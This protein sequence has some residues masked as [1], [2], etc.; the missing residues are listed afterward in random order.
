MVEAFEELK[1]A[2]QRVEGNT[3]SIKSHHPN[4]NNVELGEYDESTHF[5]GERLSQR[6]EH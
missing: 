4:F 6:Q 2:R 3:D 5:R 1:E